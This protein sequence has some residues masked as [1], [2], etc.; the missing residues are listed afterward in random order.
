MDNHNNIIAIV[1]VLLAVLAS[2]WLGGEYVRHKGLVPS[3]RPDTVVVERWLH[4]TVSVPIETV[5]VKHE[6]AYLP[7][8]DTT[9]VR[10]TTAIRDSVMVEVPIMERS[11]ASEYYRA[12]IRG[13]NPELVDIWVKQKETTITVPYRKRWGFTVGPQVGIGYTPHGWQP[14]A[15]AGITF[16][17]SF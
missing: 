3:E 2:F 7:V 12:T 1:A 10:D 17:Y 16:G 4:D 8:H 5:I 13:Y 11:Y 15:G 14:Y 9:E 6:I